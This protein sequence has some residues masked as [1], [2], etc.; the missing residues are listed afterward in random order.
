VIQRVTHLSCAL[1]SSRHSSRPPAAIKARWPYAKRS[2]GQWLVVHLV[3][4]MSSDNRRRPPKRTRFIGIPTK[5]LQGFLLFRLQLHFRRPALPSNP[6]RLGARGR[7]AASYLLGPEVGEPPGGGDEDAITMAKGDDAGNS[8][9]PSRIELHQL[10]PFKNPPFGFASS[11]L[12]T[13]VGCWRAL[14]RARLAELPCNCS[15]REER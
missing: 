2:R 11:L 1:R 5:L 10:T 4:T 9:H 14:L 13:S 8:V 6:F 3:A 15:Q 7:G 12:D